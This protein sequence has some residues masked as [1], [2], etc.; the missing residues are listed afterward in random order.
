MELKFYSCE[1]CGKIIAMVKDT[2]VPTICC[3]QPMKEIVPGSVDAAAEKHV[4]VVSVDGNIVT[5]EVG[6][7]PHPMAEEHYIEWIVLST[8]EGMQ[9]KELN[10]GDEPKA[11]FAL[12]DGDEVIGAL[13]YCNLHSLWKS[14]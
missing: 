8:K 11:E 3:G 10:P 9:R 7:V 6:S 1:I 4:P 13:A 14:K 12:T 2:G 5:V